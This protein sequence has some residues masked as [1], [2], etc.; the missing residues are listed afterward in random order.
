MHLMDDCKFVLLMILKLRLLSND[1]M[2]MHNLS[3]MKYFFLS[4]Y[5]INFGETVIL[6]QYTSWILEIMFFYMLSL[7]NRVF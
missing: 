5:F 2:M 4:W 6:E 7:L 1:S 3:D